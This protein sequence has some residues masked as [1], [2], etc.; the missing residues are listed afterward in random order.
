MNIY[1]VWKLY[2][3]DIFAYNAYNVLSIKYQYFSNK[4]NSKYRTEGRII[5]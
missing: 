2:V 5:R 3:I 1:Y 4:K